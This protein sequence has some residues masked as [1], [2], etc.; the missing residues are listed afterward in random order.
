M[1]VTGKMLGSGSIFRNFT[2][3]PKCKIFN[4]TRA[5]YVNNRCCYYCEKKDKC[6]DP[7]FND[8]KKCSMCFYPETKEGETPMWELGD[9]AL[10]DAPVIEKTE[11]FGTDDP[12]DGEETKECPICGKDADRFFYD[13][14][15][16][17]FGCNVCV[18][19]IDASEYMPE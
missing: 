12:D 16:T 13:C 8:P 6:S 7:C 5:R 1:G 11:R 10:P 2:C 9:M 15:G 19:S 17:L 4:C 3:F 18:K 14:D